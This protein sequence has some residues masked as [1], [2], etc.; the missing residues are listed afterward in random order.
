LAPEIPWQPN[1]KVKLKAKILR[2]ERY[3]NPGARSAL[4]VLDQKG[5]DATGTVADPSHIEIAQRGEWNLRGLLPRFKL[6]L[7]R[8]FT[9]RFSLDTAGIL[10]ASLLGNKQFISKDVADSFREGGAMHVL[11]ISGLHITLLGALAVFIL[12]KFMSNKSAQF[13]FSNAVV[14]VYALMVGAETPVT[15]A[16]VMFTLISFS[17]IVKRQ[18]N[19][20][21]ALAGSALLLLALNP[22]ALFDVSFQLTFVSVAAIVLMALPLLL[23]LRQ[24]GS[25]QPSNETPHPPFTGKTIR[26]FSETLFWSDDRW[27]RERKRHVWNCRL[28]KCAWAARLENYG[29]QPILRYLFASV[30]VS[31]IVQF[32][33]L[34]F[35]TVYFHRV[36]PASPFTT[37]TASLLLALT[38]VSAF[39]SLFMAQI[40]DLLAQPF[41]GFTDLLAQIMIA[42]NSPFEAATT[43]RVP[44]YDG[45]GQ[46]LYGV[47]FLPLLAL[48]FLLKKWDPFDLAG[49][50]FAVRA[51][52]S[53][54]KAAALTG[55]AV[56]AVFV[57]LIIFH[58]FS[59]EKSNGRLTIDFL[60]VGQG[61][62]AL[63]TLPDGRTMLID[64]GGR[65][66]FNEQVIIDPDGESSAFEPDTLSVG[67]AVVS[68]YLWEKGLDRID[69]LMASHSDADHIQ[70]LNDIARNFSVGSVL[71]EKTLVEEPNYKELAENA[72][73]GGAKVIYLSRGDSFEV[74]GVKFRVLN[75]SSGDEALFLSQNNRSLMIK[76]TLG[77]RSFLFTGDVET[78]TEAEL[79]QT[80]ADL[81]ADVLKVAHHGSKTSST[82]AFINAVAPQIAIIPVGRRSLYGH[83]HIEV[84]ERFA[85][86]GVTVLKTGE[87]GTVTVSTDGNDLQ[88]SAF[89]K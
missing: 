36:T 46:M 29:L 17:W 11:V 18:S 50:D 8:E 19:L 68:E 51:V 62:A 64:G 75:P 40:S 28:F 70:G 13:L 21:N 15:R 77:S 45:W 53:R 80:G 6:F 47:Y 86:R 39:A 32:W 37:I 76:A 7:L 22:A 69:Y 35:M 89:Q 66:N 44:V 41:I 85:E 63:L 14:W 71:L 49:F 48:C 10:N 84:L 52:L 25:W 83:P 33:L 57:L 26:H 56:L 1:D 61:D 81:S 3:L 23:R 82:A 79:A 72:L 74:A 2:E 60:D 30:T 43:F 5:L 31:L 9:A 27:Q 59:K 16:A 24:I 78:E 88:L 73:K 67:E 65:V 34:P 38:T 20:L 55:A 42:M 12:G 4:A 87:R 58:P 54:A